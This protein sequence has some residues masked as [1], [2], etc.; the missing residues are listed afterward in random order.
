M[1][2]GANTCKAIKP[3][4]MDKE[5]LL[6]LKLSNRSQES[7]FSPGLLIILMLTLL[8]LFSVKFSQNRTKIMRIFKTKTQC[9]CFR[10]MQI[11]MTMKKLVMNIME[12]KE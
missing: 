7:H 4:F 12:H 6:T 3:L 9:N 1:E 2:T 5:V 8:R 10:N 11:K